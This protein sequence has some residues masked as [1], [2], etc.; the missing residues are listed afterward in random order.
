MGGGTK[1]LFLFLRCASRSP[2]SHVK[3]LMQWVI[4][5]LSLGSAE[6]QSNYLHD[7]AG[8]ATF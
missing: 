6:T 2:G 7:G 8:E 4:L 5:I 3:M 1:G